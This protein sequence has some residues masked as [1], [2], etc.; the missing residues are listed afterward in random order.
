MSTK[1]AASK[2]SDQK[3]QAVLTMAVI[4]AAGRLGISNRKLATV[5]GISPSSVSRISGD[6]C[7][8]SIHKG[9]KEWELA[10]LF[11]RMFR[12]LDA[13]AGD[14]GLQAWLNSD[15]QAF[16]H[17]KP[18]DVIDSTEG[19]VHVCNYLDAHRGVI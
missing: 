7:G 3:A 14:S 6:G 1:A 11:V 8:Y 17:R 13:I 15:N 16:G 4:R 5:I 10:I 12:S 19:L 18:F 2:A 9:S